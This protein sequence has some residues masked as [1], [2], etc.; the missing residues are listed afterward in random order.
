L[1][2]AL[3]RFPEAFL[4]IALSLPRGWTRF[5]PSIFTSPGA[6]RIP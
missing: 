5:S 4:Q 2:S 1:P 6:R 3:A